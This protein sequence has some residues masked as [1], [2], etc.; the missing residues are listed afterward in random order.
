MCTW[1]W[2]HQV[3][4][5]PPHL[6]GLLPCHMSSLSPLFTF[7]LPA[8][9][10]ECFFFNSLVDRFPYSPIFWQFWLFFVFK[11]V[12]LL[13]VVWEL[14]AYLPMPPTWPEVSNRFSIPCSF[15]SPFHILMVECYISC[16]AEVPLNYPH[17]FWVFLH[18]FLLPV[19]FFLLCL[20]AYL[21][22]LLLHLACF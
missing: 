22:G 11:C 17:S 8:S 14:K 3:C 19:C 15:C 18:F 21:F 7:T 13:L 10:N 4:Q 6:L 5:T 16:C 1:M 12:V 9:L 20:P 2:D